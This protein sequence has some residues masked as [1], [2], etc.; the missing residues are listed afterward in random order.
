[1]HF[2]RGPARVYQLGPQVVR[3]AQRPRPEAGTVLDASPRM[4]TKARN[5]GALSALVWVRTI[6]AAPR[7]PRLPGKPVLAVIKANPH[8]CSF[9]DKGRYH[10]KLI[11][12]AHQLCRRLNAFCA[13]ASACS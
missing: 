2:A 13:R 7:T 12:H 3:P 4:R 5:G 1:M 9:T 11:F 8:N 6:H 10:A